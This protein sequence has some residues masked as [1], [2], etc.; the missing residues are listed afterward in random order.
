M[1]AHTLFLECFIV[2][3]LV[4]CSISP[5]VLEIHLNQSS[6]HF[7]LPPTRRK[8]VKERL[9]LTLT[10]TQTKWISLLHHLCVCFLC[11]NIFMNIL[12]NMQKNQHVWKYTIQWPFPLTALSLDFKRTGASS[13]LMSGS[14]AAPDH[15]QTARF[16]HP[17]GGVWCL[18]YVS[19]HRLSSRVADA[20]FCS[21]PSTSSRQLRFRATDF[22]RE[23]R[24]HWNV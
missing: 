19:E 11:C 13:R 20:V 10:H 14:T 16:G 2:F 8:V 23:T 9:I 18:L 1:I 12:R 7:Q 24:T 4:T 3:W 15:V 21:Q 5:L 17:V 22:D 6:P